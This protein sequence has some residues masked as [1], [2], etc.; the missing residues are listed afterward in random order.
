MLG[1]EMKLVV[2]TP[3]HTVPP[4]DQVR[5]LPRHLGTCNPLFAPPRPVHGLGFDDFLAYDRSPSS[6]GRSVASV[7]GAGGV[8]F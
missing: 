3:V 5:R 8:R 2:E 4:E 7:A 1:E 6:H